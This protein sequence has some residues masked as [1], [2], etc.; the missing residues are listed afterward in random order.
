MQDERCQLH[1]RQERAEH[2]ASGKRVG[3]RS[4]SAGLEEMGGAG[5]KG[6]EAI[7]VGRERSEDGRT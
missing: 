7:Q 5:G 6:Q 2:R 4:L 3:W 1:G